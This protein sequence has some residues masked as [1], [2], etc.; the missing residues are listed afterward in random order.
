VCSEDEGEAPIYRVEGWPRRTGQVIDGDVATEAPRSGRGCR[1]VPGV[2]AVLVR[3]VV[4]Q[5]VDGM[6]RATSSSSQ[7]RGGERRRWCLL[8]GERGQVRLSRG[9][10]GSWRGYMREERARG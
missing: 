2:M 1:T 3:V 8:Q 9:L 7:Y 4:Q 5:G 10:L 6:A